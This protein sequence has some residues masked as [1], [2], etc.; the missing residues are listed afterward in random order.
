MQK[1]KRFSS[2][3]WVAL[4][5]DKLTY[6]IKCSGTRLLLQTK[7]KTNKKEQITIQEST[8]NERKVG[9]F[10]LHI[11]FYNIKSENIYF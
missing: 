4:N 3:K 9:H 7:K 10:N 8:T 6:C 11:I 1:N 2:M 5:Q